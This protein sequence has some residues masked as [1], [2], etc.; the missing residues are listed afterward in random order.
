MGEG[1]KAQTQSRDPGHLCGI[2]Q[3]REKRKEGSRVLSLDPSV[4]VGQ[5]RIHSKLAG[6]FGG[7]GR[8]LKSRG[9]TSENERVPVGPEP[10]SHPTVTND[11]LL[12]TQPMMMRAL[13]R[14]AGALVGGQPLRTRL[15]KNR[16]SRALLRG[17]TAMEWAVP[18]LPPTVS[19]RPIGDRKWG[20]R[21]LAY[22]RRPD[23]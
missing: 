17:V 11:R 6:N 7:G 23:R 14:G 4:E 1:R 9:W 20:A 5:G 16:F 18:P 8:V 12:P 10:S 22:G 2:H 3:S 13:L 21:R 15:T 19:H